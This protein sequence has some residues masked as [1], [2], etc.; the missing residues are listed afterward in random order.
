MS[1]N[2]ETLRVVGNNLTPHLIMEGKTKIKNR[3]QSSQ[4]CC[5]NGDILKR[6]KTKFCDS[7]PRK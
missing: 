6:E 3:R 4:I 7:S 2:I 5:S 1:D